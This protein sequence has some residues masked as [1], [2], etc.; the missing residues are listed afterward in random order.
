MDL[1][2]LR[3]F[4]TV[5]RTLHFTRASEELNLSQPAVS[6]QIKTLEKELGEQLFVRDRRSVSLTPSG[7]VMLEH[8]DKI[9]NITDALREEIEETKGRAES[10]ITLGMVYRGLDSNFSELYRQF[11]KA[12]PEIELKFRVEPDAASLRT[13]IR[14]GKVNLGVISEEEEIKNDEFVSIAYGW[15]RLILV[16]GADHP[17]TKLK[18][19]DLTNLRNVRWGFFEKSDPLRRVSDEALSASGI[20]PK[21]VFETNDGAAIRNLIAVGDLIGFLPSTGIVK[22]LESGELVELNVNGLG[23]EAETFLFWKP[24]PKTP[25]VET[26]VR[27]MIERE[28][29]GLKL[30]KDSSKS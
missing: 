15:N 29:P 27:F 30:S 4:R 16:A 26:L 7:E 11:R 1:W 23:P 20:E 6:H 2:H 3:T 12:H 13:A 10:T 9:L 22:Q 18:K 14:L 5:A 24:G 25:S 28:L 21:S 8:A 19:V 17:L